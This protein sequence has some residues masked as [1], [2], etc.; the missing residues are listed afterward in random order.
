MLQR[1]LLQSKTEVNSLMNRVYAPYGSFVFLGITI[2]QACNLLLL[3]VNIAA[4]VL[5]W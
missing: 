1:L 5:L 3:Q 4:V 2:G